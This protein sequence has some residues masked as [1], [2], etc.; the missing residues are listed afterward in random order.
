MPHPLCCRPNSRSVTP[1]PV[2]TRPLRPS[3]RGSP[4]GLCTM[5][6]TETLITPATCAFMNRSLY[7]HTTPAGLEH[8]RDHSSLPETTLHARFWSLKHSS[9][10]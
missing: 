6:G 4:G 1:T 5:N 8:A 9:L 10:R 2:S 3:P 7:D